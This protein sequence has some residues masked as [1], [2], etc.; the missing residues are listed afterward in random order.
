MDKDNRILEDHKNKKSSFFKKLN[1]FIGELHQQETRLLKVLNFLSIQKLILFTLVY[2]YWID[3]AKTGFNNVYSIFSFDYLNDQVKWVINKD[4][5]LLFNNLLFILLLYSVFKMFG[6]LISKKNNYLG[7]LLSLKKLLSSVLRLGTLF[8]VIA[9]FKQE[10]QYGEIREIVTQ[11]IVFLVVLVIVT[12]I[13]KITLLMLQKN[14]TRDLELK[15]IT[16]QTKY[17][18]LNN[19]PVL[20]L[21]KNSKWLPYINT[22]SK[23]NERINNIFGQEIYDSLG[24]DGVFAIDHRITLNKVIMNYEIKL[25]R[26]NNKLPGKQEKGNIVYLSEL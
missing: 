18:N 12:L 22:V 7:T 2:K 19:V 15:N 21:K 8:L 3:I 1:S 9:L 4:G 23:N 25:K 26:V 10:I 11:T 13:E 5:S 24:K 6:F 17:G 14:I 20:V 16:I